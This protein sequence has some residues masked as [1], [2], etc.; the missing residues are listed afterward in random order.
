MSPSPLPLITESDFPG[1]QRIIRELDQVS[2]HEWVDDHV[3]A[4]AYRRSRNG[5]QEI[6]ISP[7]EFDLWLKEHEMSPHLELLWVCVEDKAKG[8]SQLTPALS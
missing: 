3:K 6:A 8:I 5:S 7:E 2:Y 1:F 4:V